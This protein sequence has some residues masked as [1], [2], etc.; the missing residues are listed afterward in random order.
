MDIERAKQIME[1]ADPQ[2]AEQWLIF[3]SEEQMALETKLLNQIVS[4]E[5]FEIHVIF[6]GPGTGKTQVLLLLAQELLDNNLQVGYFSSVGVRKMV[7]NAGLEMPRENIQVGS[8]HL[9]DD[10]LE[11]GNLTKA[12]HRARKNSA[13]AIVIAIDPFQWTE[14]NAFVKLA[15]FFGER[16]QLRGI[17]TV[18]Q[19]QNFTMPDTWKTAIHRYFLTT[20][21]R[22]KHDAG[23]GSV[24]LTQSLVQRMNPYIHFEK[25]Q[26]FLNITKPY[27]ANILE[28]TKHVIAGGAFKVV[29]DADGFAVWQAVANLASRLDTWNW[30]EPILFVKDGDQDSFRW[31]SFRV[32]IRGLTDQDD[33][34]TN[35]TLNQ[36]LINLKAR[37]V[38][39]NNPG[40][41]RG[42]EFQDVIICISAERW[43]LLNKFKEGVGSDSWTKIMPIHTFTTRAVDSVQIIVGR[44]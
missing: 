7:T 25:K 30:T 23:A 11:I 1:A 40:I 15:S 36:V 10:P 22:Q 27:I 37:V 20:A 18:N 28:G 12:V 4:N 39:F 34:D 17:D 29:E 24:E 43:K 21:Y 13:R 6:G 19:R 26:A 32:P 35:S 38:H 5:E 2:I 42:Q 8:V 16:D 33:F 44:D 3:L 14:R 9:V 41:V 31:D